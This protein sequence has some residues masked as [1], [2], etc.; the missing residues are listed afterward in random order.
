MLSQSFWAQ[1]QIRPTKIPAPRASVMASSRRSILELEFLL[2]PV[3]EGGGRV[4]WS[5]LSADK[6][7]GYFYFVPHLVELHHPFTRAPLF[8]QHFFTERAMILRGTPNP[9]T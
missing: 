1:A 6:G 7:L 4:A 9:G 5:C 2:E 8:H 3:R